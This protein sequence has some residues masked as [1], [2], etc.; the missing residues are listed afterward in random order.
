ML[1]ALFAEPPDHPLNRAGA[2]FGLVA[3]RCLRQLNARRLGGSD[4][5]INRC[6]HRFLEF[7]AE[8][9]LRRYRSS[10]E[11]E[12]D[13][14]LSLSVGTGRYRSSTIHGTG[15]PDPGCGAQNLGSEQSHD[16]Y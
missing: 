1:R 11:R 9:A 8:L 3:F 12:S 7:T 16:R 4:M 13:H 6:Q 15:H 5:A 14:G 2:A 10:V